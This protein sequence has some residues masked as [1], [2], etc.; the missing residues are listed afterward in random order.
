MRRYKTSNIRLKLRILSLI[1]ITSIGVSGCAASHYR[2]R[3]SQNPLGLEM[4]D[5]RKI[6]I[7]A[8]KYIES[9]YRIIEDDEINKKLNRIG[10]KLAEVCERPL[11]GYNF[12]ILDSDEFNAMSLPDGYVY[13]FRGLLKL[14]DDEERIAAVLAHEIAHV[15]RSHAMKRLYAMQDQQTILL[16]LSVGIS[17]VMSHEGT[18]Q[19]TRDE[20]S[21]LMRLGAQIS[22][23][24]LYTGYSQSAE[25]QADRLGMIYM[26]R[27]GYN[28]EKFVE[29]LKR[30]KQVE[31][32]TPHTGIFRTHPEIQVRIKEAEEFLKI[33]PDLIENQEIKRYYIGAEF[34]WDYDK[35][36]PVVVNIIKGS[37]ADKTDLRLTDV[38]LEINGHS[39]DLR[40]RGDFELLMRDKIRGEFDKGICNILVKRQGIE[41]LIK[42]KPAPIYKDPDVLNL[43]TYD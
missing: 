8:S 28:P 6:S 31:K 13:I 17:A 12:K 40:C 36:K 3:L 33:L 39:T 23:M 25:R 42:I 7:A 32:E 21:Q 14:A 24:I 16:G 43:L 26:K 29:M 30:L 9:E 15:S 20:V 38:V 10:Q 19:A 37:P 5:E 22:Q 34:K 2:A 27:A 11:I 1:L 35:E 41:K 4:P 18:S